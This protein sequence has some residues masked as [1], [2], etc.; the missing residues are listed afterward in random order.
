MIR[1]IINILLAGTLLLGLSACTDDPQCGDN[2][3]GEG[4]SVVSFGAT[5]RP[6]ANASLGKTR[7][8]KGD[9][10]GGIGD[11]FVVWYLEDGTLAGSRYFT[12]EELTL[13]Y[14]ER[15]D[16]KTERR[17]WHAAFECRIPYGRYRIY[18][19]AN[20]GDLSDSESIGTEKG[21]RAI[22]LTWREDDVTKNSQ[23]SGYFSDKVSTAYGK[24][25]PQLLSIA[26]PNVSLHA[27]IRRAASKVTVSFNAEKLNEN[28]YIYLKSAQI[29]DIPLHCKLV[30]KNTPASDDELLSEGDTILYGAGTDYAEWPRL[31]AG[32]GANTFG[33][34]AADAPSLFFFENMQG[35][36]P[37]KHQY[38]NFDR[39]DNVLY[40]TYV[41]VEGYYINRSV[42][43]P[44]YGAITYRCM[45]GRNMED[46]FDA[47]RNT[48]YKLMLVFNKDANNPDWHIEYDYVPQPPEIVV[49]SP[50]YIS[51]LSNQQ[52]TIPLTVYYDKN[53]TKVTKITA[54]IVGNDWGYSDHPYIHK[55]DNALTNGFL[56]LDLI[57]KTAVGNRKTE[58]TGMKTYTVPV[59]QDDTRYRFDIPVYTR[60]MTLGDGFS[61]NNYYVGRRRH[62]K[63]RFTAWNDGTKLTEKIVEVIQSRRLV[64]PKGI[65]RKGSSVKE[66][67]ITLKN[68]D[69]SPNV[70]HEFEDLTSDGPWTARILDGADWVRIKDVESTVWGT[71]PVTGGTG[72]KIEFDYRP[73]T[74]FAEG[75]RFGRIEITFHN[76]TCTHVI[77]VS[78]GLG[79]VEIE[80][81]KWH[82]TN[83]GYLGADTDN[84]L[85]EGSMFKFGNAVDAIASSNNLKD[86]YGFNMACYDKS[87]DVYDAS[88]R[89]VSKKFSAIPAY[90]TGFTDAGMTK[91]IR[92]DDKPCRIATHTDWQALTSETQFIRYY[93][94]LY[95]E[96]CDRTLDSN[97]VTNTYTEEGQERG[98]RGCFIYDRKSQKHLFFPVGNTGYGRRKHRDQTSSSSPVR[99][100]GVLKYANRAEEM[101]ATTAVKLPSFYDLYTSTGALYYYGQ[102][103]LKAGKSPT[104]D[105]DLDYDYGFDVN[106]FTFGFESFQTNIINV[107]ANSPSQI[108]SDAGFLRRIDE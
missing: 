15:P 73:A 29:R 2:P 100:Y 21:F 30:D 12:R 83:V 4:E 62:A 77:L 8:V 14:E 80:G 50:M 106:Y 78:Q 99:G 18:A 103:S 31:S 13:S 34:H 96:E 51:Y 85:L 91:D 44:S 93:G 53:I 65:W 27:W 25:E 23:M 66:F 41:E 108:S 95:G 74:T 84:P 61:G 3:A 39:K 46:D 36:H 104:S 101:D 49:A 10:I 11:L 86:G 107:D 48:H 1:T 59:S 64:N 38:N 75:S 28:I 7:S 87:F 43:N 81:R 33:S 72:S 47:E 22:Q 17:T 67:R 69:S 56:S 98:M 102:R 70:A 55:A 97:S 20:A 9:A 90:R 16:S 76:N 52:L 32:R 6:L 94:I 79:P 45:L 19:V 60:P 92:N 5:F 57:N 26:A 40:G 63:V 82:M 68:S 35:Q 58:Y 54:E 88:G 105:N 24:G 42:D 37:D 71:E 89:L